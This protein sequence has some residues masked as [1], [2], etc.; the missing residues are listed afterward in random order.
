M[1]NATVSDT[2]VNLV[3]SRRRSLVRTKKIRPLTIAVSLRL[4]P[5]ND[6]PERAS[7]WLRQPRCERPGLK[8]QIGKR[9]DADARQQDLVLGVGDR[10]ADILVQ[11]VVADEADDHFAGSEIGRIELGLVADF[12][13]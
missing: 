7:P 5:R 4:L 11:Q 13:L 12:R 1:T 3:D 6:S 2:K 10:V 8:F 9:P